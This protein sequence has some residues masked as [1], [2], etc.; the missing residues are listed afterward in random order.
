MTS[1][2]LQLA[3]AASSH[4]SG[5]GTWVLVG[6]SFAV[7]VAGAGL[8]LINNRSSRRELRREWMSRSELETW[9]AAQFA[10]RYQWQVDPEKPWVEADRQHPQ[11]SVETERDLLHSLR[12]QI[13]LPAGERGDQDDGS[14]ESSER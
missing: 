8:S 13:G 5:A 4:S 7:A 10:A 2:V 14:A 11:G 6:I 1:A 9:R 12:E 3:A